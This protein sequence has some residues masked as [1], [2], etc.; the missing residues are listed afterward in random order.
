MLTKITRV[1]SAQIHT[2]FIR[3]PLGIIQYYHLCPLYIPPLCTTHHHLG[4]SSLPVFLEWLYLCHC[5]VHCLWHE[6]NQ[7]ALQSIQRMEQQTIKTLRNK[8]KP[9]HGGEEYKGQRLTEI[10]LFLHEAGSAQ[11]IVI[12]SSVNCFMG[13]VMGM[14]PYL[15]WL[16]RSFTKTCTLPK[17]NDVMYVR[18]CVHHRRGSKRS[19]L[20]LFKLQR[21]DWNDTYLTW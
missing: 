4:K 7:R 3:H 10:G 20:K 1:I 2:K 15:M 5:F 12:W 9:P 16:C 8:S 11:R 19:F 17:K 6:G 13:S 18:A 14:P 21:R